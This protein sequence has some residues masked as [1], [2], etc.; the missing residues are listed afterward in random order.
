[1]IKRILFL[2]ILVLSAVN[3]Q[4]QDIV[5]TKEKHEQLRKNIEDYKNLI[6]VHKTLQTKTDALTKENEKLKL[7]ITNLQ[8]QLADCQNKPVKKP[9]VFKRF[10]KWVKKTTGKIKFRKNKQDW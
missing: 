3:L 8:S 7:T 5:M 2:L 4:A 6:K 1:M 9:N 10:G